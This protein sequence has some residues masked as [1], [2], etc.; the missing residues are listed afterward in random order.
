MFNCASVILFYSAI[1]LKS[2]QTQILAMLAN[3]TLL[4]PAVNVKLHKY[5]IQRVNPVQQAKIGQL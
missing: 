4:A 1:N 2:A 5:G 3:K